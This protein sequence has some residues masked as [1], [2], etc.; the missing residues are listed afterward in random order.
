[1]EADRSGGSFRPLQSAVLGQW[2][3][4]TDL[5]VTGARTLTLPLED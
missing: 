2:E 4:P 3:I 5:A 1:M